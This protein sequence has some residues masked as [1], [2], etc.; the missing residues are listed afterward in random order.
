MTVW[1]RILKRVVRHLAFTLPVAVTFLDC[2]SYVAK[3]EGVSMQPELNPEQEDGK[4]LSDYVLLN[5]W[6]ARYFDINRGDVVTLLSPRDPSQKIIKRVVALE[7]DV[8]RTLNY[9]EKYVKVP[10]GHCWVEGDHH[11]HSMDSNYFGPVSIGLVTAIATHVVWPP[12]RCRRLEPNLPTK[13]KPVN[14][15]FPV[16]SWLE[17]QDQD[18]EE[19][20]D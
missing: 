12:T 14:V 11:S 9:K 1:S 20:I 10:Q 7:G 17:E 5:R 13:R 2:V 6:K 18:L 4:I 8:I 19:Y 15:G 16:F 3:V